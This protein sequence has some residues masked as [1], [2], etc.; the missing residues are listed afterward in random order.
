MGIFDDI[1]GTAD[2]NEEKIEA[3]IDQAGDF[4][5]EKTGGRYA[6]QVDQAQAF[7]KDQIGQ[8]ESEQA[9]AEPVADQQPVE[10]EQA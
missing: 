2:A 4:I 9:R 1:K 8:K 7:L 10:G 5:D 3:V 6:E